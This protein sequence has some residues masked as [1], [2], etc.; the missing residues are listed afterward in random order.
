MTV[1]VPSSILLLVRKANC[2]LSI[3]DIT[4]NLSLGSMPRPKHLDN[5]AAK[6]IGCRSLSSLERVFSLAF[7]RQILIFGII[8]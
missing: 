4:K 8:L 7:Y 3:L 5:M 6:L 2:R 1:L